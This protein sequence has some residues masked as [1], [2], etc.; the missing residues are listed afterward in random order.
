M[1]PP[2]HISSLPPSPLPSD[3]SIINDFFIFD[4]RIIGRQRWQR[5]EEGGRKWVGCGHRYL[6]NID[7]YVL[8]RF[9]NSRWP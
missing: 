5:R 9:N 2:H 1:T 4:D 6:N 7:C 3:D 8:Y